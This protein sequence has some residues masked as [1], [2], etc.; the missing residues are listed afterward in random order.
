MWDAEAGTGRPQQVRA[1]KQRGGAAVEFA[2]LVLLFLTIVCGILELARLIYL[3]NTLQEV[4]RRA[5]ATAVNSA[6]DT[7]AQGDVQNGAVFPDQKGNLV[8]GAPVTPGHIQLHYLSLA[9]GAGGAL[10]MQIVDPLPASPAQNRLNCLADPYG[11]NCIRLV[12]VRICQPGSGTG[13]APVPYRMLFPLVDFSRLTLPRSETLAPAQTL[14][15]MPG[16][17][18]AP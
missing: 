18:P 13:C 4:T 7:T 16:D 12:R 14:G 6:F 2:L 17:L 8:L 5:A 9:R 15:Y 3:F 10:T 11:A 1:A